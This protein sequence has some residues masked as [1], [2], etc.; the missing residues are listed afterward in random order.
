M[1]LDMIMNNRRKQV[2]ELKQRLPLPVIT[3]NAFDH[4]MSYKTRDLFGTLKGKGL[5]VI[6]EIKKCGRPEEVN[7]D[8]YDPVEL[9]VELEKA[10]AQAVSVVTE[11]TF[12]KGMADHFRAVRSMVNVPVVRKDFIF[13][14]WQIC[15]SRLL[16][17]DAV[18][19]IASVLEF[20]ELKKLIA[21]A[22]MLDMQCIVETRSEEE[23]DF[24]IRAGA[25]II[26][27]ASRNLQTFETD[28]AKAFSMRPYIPDDLVYAVSGGIQTA[29]DI[30]T[31]TQAG[32]D[33]V[34][35][36]SVLMR[37]QSAGEKLSSLIEGDALAR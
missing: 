11:E 22:K 28:L 33:A 26:C 34:I 7:R 10:G 25:K 4:L 18:F 3:K 17:A 29:D 30:R 20:F 2:H 1:I 12:F 8:S 13:D 9:A 14:E 21:T 32:A 31:A 27:A 16:G 15:E 35:V 37:A 36:G 19:L 24:A 23:I 5:S 6:T